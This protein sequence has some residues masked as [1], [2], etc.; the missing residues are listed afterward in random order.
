MVETFIWQYLQDFSQML[1]DE[2]FRNRLLN[3]QS[4]SEFLALID[5]QEAA[6]EAKETAK[7]AAT[8]KINIV[9]V[10]ACPTGIAH[11]YMAAEALEAAAKE[12]GYVAKIETQGSGGAKSVLTKADVEQAD[13]VIIAA[14]KNVE[15]ARFDGKRVI[16]VPVAKGI[17]DAKE[18]VEK[19]MAGEGKVYTHSGAQASFGDEGN[20]SF[21]RTIY[22]HLMNGVSNMLPFV[23]GGGD[24]DR[25]GIPIRFT[26]Y[27]RHK[28]RF[29]WW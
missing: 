25:L 9:G 7:T 8:G 26:F 16:S 4:A 22:K 19:A 6:K 5:E 29:I 27:K 18:L 20:E 14:D 17:H 15:M 3:A 24:F 12:L 11:T 1:M 2:S 23:I 21:G 10:T 13:A 28:L